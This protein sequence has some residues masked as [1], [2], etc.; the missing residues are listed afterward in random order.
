MEAIIRLPGIQHGF[1][2]R[3]SKDVITP[4]AV[5]DEYLTLSA[6]GK[7]KEFIAKDVEDFRYMK[8]VSHWTCFSEF[9]PQ[10]EF[11]SLPLDELRTLMEKAKT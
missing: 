9:N 4:Q 7:R 11:R 10:L 6:G 5:I 8:W 1:K 2:H 3:E